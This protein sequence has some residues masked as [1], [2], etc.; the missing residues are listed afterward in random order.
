MNGS[1]VAAATGAYS[2]MYYGYDP[3]LAIIM[4]VFLLHASE[5]I[6]AKICGFF[7]DFRMP[8]ALVVR[9]LM[10]PVMFVDALLVDEYTWHG[11]KIKIKEADEFISIT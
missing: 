11:E 10:L 5:L 8:L 3:I 2:S 6:L 4:I 1:F 7:I 9:D